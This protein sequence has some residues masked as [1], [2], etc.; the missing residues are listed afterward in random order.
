MRTLILLAAP[1]APH[2]A[3]EAWAKLGESG[4][5]ADAAWP[6]YDPAM[7]V[8][9][10]VTL[11]VQVN[12]KLRDTLTAPRGLD[13]AAA[14]ALALGVRQ[15]HPAARRGDAAQSDCRSRPAG[16]YRPVT[17]A[18]LLFLR[19]RAERLRPAPAL[20]RRRILVGRAGVAHDRGRQDPRPGRLADSQRPGRPAGRRGRWRGQISA[21]GRARR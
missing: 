9:D 20:W 1:M 2:L 13:R 17:R 5:I 18:L 19:D 10:E 15:G 3:E 4:L 11:A 7:L 8:D 16:Q 6:T 12:G 21:R 14:E